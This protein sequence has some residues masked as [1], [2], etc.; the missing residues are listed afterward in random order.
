[1]ATPPL[2]PHRRAF[3]L[4]RISSDCG[5]RYLVSWRR[6]RRPRARSGRPASARSMRG[7]RQPSSAPWAE[8]ERS[9]VDLAEY[10]VDGAEN[11]G[12]VGQHVAAAEE[13]HR[14]EMGEARR[15]DLALVGL[16]G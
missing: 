15:A 4:P 10:D 7:I 2:E 9:S 16:V 8:R 12:D 3:E 5:G 13:I 6:S 14:L 1:M 11:G